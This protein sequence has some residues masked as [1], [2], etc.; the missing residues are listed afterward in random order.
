MISPIYCSL[1]GL[2]LIALSIN[3]IRARRVHKIALGDENIEIKRHFRAQA[4]LSE[5][6]PIFLI[7]LFC[8]ENLGISAALIHLH[9]ILFL[10]ARLMHSY[11][12]VFDEKYENNKLINKP[13]WRIR[14]MFCTFASIG[15][16][17]L[18]CLFNSF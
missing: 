10:I 14:G 17:A 15:S 4:N 16:L 6:A 13:I 5:Y 3:V 7:L 8:A 1:T 18:F 11:S 12:L 2:F 9:G